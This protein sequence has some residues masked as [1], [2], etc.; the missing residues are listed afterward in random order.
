MVVSPSLKFNFLRRS[1]LLFAGWISRYISKIGING[2]KC[3]ELREFDGIVPMLQMTPNTKNR[4]CSYE[5]KFL[6]ENKSFSWY[7][8][9][10]QHEEPP[11]RKRG[12]FSIIK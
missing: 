4:P 1:K 7:N 9:N 12:G 2:S 6:F 3:D 8:W 10:H 5:T 11:L